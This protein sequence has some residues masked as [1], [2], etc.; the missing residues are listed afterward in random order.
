MDGPSNRGANSNGQRSQRI[1]CPV[2]GCLD[3][4]ESSHRYFRDFLSI[5]SHLNDHCTGHLAGAVPISFLT[6]ND[7]SL[8][9]ICNKVLHIRYHGTCPK[10]QPYART[11]DHLTSIRVNGNTRNNGT[12]HGQG[13]SQEN[14]EKHSAQSSRCA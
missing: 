1:L 8:C 2:P 5:K 6:Q 10:C 12:Q 13:S 3:A 9:E 7:Y 11:R 14:E 4:I